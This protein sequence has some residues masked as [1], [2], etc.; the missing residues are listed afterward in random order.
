MIEIN[1]IYNDDC[2]NILKKI[3]DNSID[4]IITSPP[5]NLGKTHHTGNDIHVPY[6]DNLPEKEYQNWQIGILNELYRILKYNGNCFYNHK[7]RI[8]EGFCISPLE[9]IFKSKFNLKQEIIWKNGG[10]NLDKIRFFPMHEKIFWL[11]KSNTTIDNKL[12]LTDVWDYIDLLS[13][14]HN[15]HRRAFPVL[16]PM[17]LLQVAT[18]ENDLV[19]DCFSGSGTT[20]IACSELKRRFICIEKDKQYYEA[21]VKRLENYNKQLKLF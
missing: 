15:F 16:L 11:S 18:K 17:K 10:Q 20:A 8:K 21:S 1:K 3:P 12:N 5:Y 9:W 2:L 7:N 13:E 14:K 19:L 4:C 6:F